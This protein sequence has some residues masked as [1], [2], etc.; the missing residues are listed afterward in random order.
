MVT[1]IH[2][3]DEEKLRTVNLL[4]NILK[5]E[6]LVYLND[7]DLQINF[8]KGNYSSKTWIYYLVYNAVVSPVIRF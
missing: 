1:L 2:Y 5:N 7:A 8:T 4:C 3:A 6:F